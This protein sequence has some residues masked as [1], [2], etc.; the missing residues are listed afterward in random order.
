MVEQ[1]D[2]HDSPRKDERELHPFE[3]GAP[4]LHVQVSHAQ[5]AVSVPS[6][7]RAHASQMV[8]STKPT[9]R[10]GTEP[11]GPVASCV[12]P[13]P[14]LPDSPPLQPPGH[15]GPGA[16]PGTVWA[17]VAAVFRE[18]LVRNIIIALG[19]VLHTCTPSIGRLR[20]ERHWGFKASLG[21]IVRPCQTN[22]IFKSSD[23]V[24][25]PPLTAH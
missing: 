6:P 11:A 25:S 2:T 14:D 19:V 3:Q 18:R 7:K 22:K 23:Q 24:Q 17:C 10:A 12:A 13:R 9:Y 1:G 8:A 20:Q 21:Y 16:S 15:V 4:C 5:S